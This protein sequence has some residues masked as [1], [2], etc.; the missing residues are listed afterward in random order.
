MIVAS[1][2][3]GTLTTGSPILAVA[4]WAGLQQSGPA[5]KFFK[6]RILISYFQVR[7]GLMDL[8]IWADHNLRAVLD[9]ISSPTQEKL[10][11]VMSY[12]VEDELWP[13][14]RQ[15]AVDLLRDFHQQGA[16]IMLVSA[17]FEPAVELFGKKIASSRI[18][19]IGTPVSLAQGRLSLAEH[20]TV[21]DK[22][23]ERIKAKLGSGKLDYALGD[24]IA[25]LP[26]LEAAKEAIAVAP[27]QQLRSIALQKGW[28]ILE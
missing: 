8:D 15:T 27:D 7:L 6:F 3:N 13:K 23:M 4:N 5:P 24:T 28:R 26:M 20:L 21:R 19:G 18:T 1:D 12:I 10:D 16:E 17:A 2:L 14:R 25:D 22:K 11:S 9:L